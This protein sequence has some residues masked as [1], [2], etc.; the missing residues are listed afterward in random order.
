MEKNVTF[1]DLKQMSDDIKNI[2]NI[3]K[4][5]DFDYVYNIRKILKKVKSEMENVRECLKDDVDEF[6]D[7]RQKLFELAE[8]CGAE[9]KENDGSVTLN[10]ETDEFD[11][12]KFTEKQKELEEEYKQ[13][14]EKQ[15]E[16]QQHNKDIIENKEVEVDFPT[17]PKEAFSNE[18]NFDELPDSLIDLIE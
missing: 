6:S 2:V 18:I 5:H 4:D 10:F 17:I 13:T 8:N 14:L 9:K 11:E 15:K 3:D 16:I 12:D 1:L 7:Y